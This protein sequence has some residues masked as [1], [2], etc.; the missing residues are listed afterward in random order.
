MVF[1]G[2]TASPPAGGEEH[3]NAWSYTMSNSWTEM[4]AEAPWGD[5]FAYDVQSDRAIVVAGEGQ[6]WVY[7][8]TA[9]AW[10]SRTP[11]S[12]IRLRHSCRIRHRVG[13][14]DPVGWGRRDLGL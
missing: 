13:S 7:D 12:Q 9:D 3:D 5:A 6:T 14:N 1:T 10:S 4:T 2:Q 11:W 8:A